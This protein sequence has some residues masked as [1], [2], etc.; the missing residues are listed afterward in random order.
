[1]TSEAKITAN[2]RNARRSTGPKSSSGKARSSRNA[3]SHGLAVPVSALYNFSQEIEAL[4]LAFAGGDRSDANRLEWAR[5]AAEADCDVRRVRSAKQRLLEQACNEA[6]GR[7]HGDG[8]VRSSSHAATAEQGLVPSD[9]Q[10]NPATYPGST[11]ATALAEVASD[12][13][14]LDRYERRALSRRRA[15][16]RKL[17]V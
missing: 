13:M 1:M 15:A 4:A 5:V 6:T 17:D 11:L 14:R 9:T 3:F 12:L 7:N 2:R 16:L 8:K 10:C